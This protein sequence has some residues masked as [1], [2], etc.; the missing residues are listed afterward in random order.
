MLGGERCAH[1]ELQIHGVGVI[2]ASGVATGARADGVTP[3]ASRTVSLNW[4][5]LPNPAA[6]AISVKSRW[7]V[8]M[9]TR[10]VWARCARAMASGPAPSS[11]VI[12]RVD[13]ALAVSEALGEAAHA[14]AVDDAVGDEP[15]RPGDGVPRA[16]HSG[17]PGEAS[18]RHRLHAR[19]PR[20]WAAA[21][22]GKNSTLARLGVIAGQLGRQ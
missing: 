22:V 4:R 14:F 7:V 11:S 16:S 1:G 8:S 12:S 19:Y 6:K 13:V 2:V 5:T 18:G 9:S 10:A 3:N 17:E 15:H 20:C 21:A